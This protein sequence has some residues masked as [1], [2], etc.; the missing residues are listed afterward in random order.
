MTWDLETGP[1][2]K[3]LLAQEKAGRDVPELLKRPVLN[4]EEQVF[5]TAFE[6]LSTERSSGFSPGPIP[7]SAVRRYALEEGINF[8]ELWT[9][10]EALDEQWRAG[11]AKATPNS[12]DGNGRLS[13]QNLRGSVRR[14]RRKSEGDEGG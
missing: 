2:L 10:V 11:V 13:D 6:R 7:Y 5:M 4:R 14:G 1:R 9:V 8:Y 12:G 3:R